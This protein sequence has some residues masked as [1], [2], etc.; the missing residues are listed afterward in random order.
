MKKSSEF[1]LD[2]KDFMDSNIPKAT[3]GISKSLRGIFRR[4]NS[5]QKDIETLTRFAELKQKGI[6]TTKEFNSI[7]KKILSKI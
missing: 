3:R 1:F 6:I 7:K 2:S 4:Q 5:T